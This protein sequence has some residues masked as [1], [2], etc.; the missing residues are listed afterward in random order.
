MGITLSAFFAAGIALLAYIQ[1]I[2]DASQAGLD[3]FIFGQ[4]AAII[5]SDVRLISALGLLVLGLVALLWKEFKLFTFD[6][7]FASVN[8]FRVG[9]IKGILSALIVVTIV[10]GLQLAGVI[11]MVGMLYRAGHRR[12]PMDGQPG[13]DGHPGSGLWRIRWRGP[14][15]SSARWIATSRPAP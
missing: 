8:G 14:A 1:S 10:L 2:P 15:P 3:S 12:S 11:L 5:E 9:W 13:P 4:A 7:Q 6:P